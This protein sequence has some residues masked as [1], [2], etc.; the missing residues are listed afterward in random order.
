MALRGV[1]TLNQQLLDRKVYPHQCER[2]PW[3]E[4]KTL[5]DRASDQESHELIDAKLYDTS[6]TKWTRGFKTILVFINFPSLMIPS[7]AVSPANLYSTIILGFHSKYINGQEKQMSN[8]SK[9][10][11]WLLEIKIDINMVLVSIGSCTKVVTIY[12]L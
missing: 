12:L 7:S 3:R 8:D 4:E 11:S 5:Q 10:G 9:L 2:E 6:H 1:W